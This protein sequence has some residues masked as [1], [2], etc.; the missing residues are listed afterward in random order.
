MILIRTLVCPIWWPGGGISL[1]RSRPPGRSPRGAPG[2]RPTSDWPPGWT[3]AWAR[4]SKWHEDLRRWMWGNTT[5]SESSLG[6]TEWERAT[7][8]WG[9]QSG[10]TCPA[11]SGRWG[12]STR[13]W[14]KMQRG[15]KSL[16]RGNLI[17]GIGSCSSR[18]RWDIGHDPSSCRCTGV[19]SSWAGRSNCGNPAALSLHQ[20]RSWRLRSL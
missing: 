6:T 5:S 4:R 2:S 18:S 19:S 17:P 1:P 12:P 15:K 13:R 9:T 14:R 11:V 8:V 7:S 16:H 3:P 10:C 20:S